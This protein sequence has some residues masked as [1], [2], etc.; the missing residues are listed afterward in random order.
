MIMAWGK[1]EK[2][3]G[4]KRKKREKKNAGQY[5]TPDDDCKNIGKQY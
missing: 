2:K 3:K 1:R 5:K 4:E